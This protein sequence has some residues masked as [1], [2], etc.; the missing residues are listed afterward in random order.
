MNFN[1]FYLNSFKDSNDI[2]DGSNV[3]IK[4]NVAVNKLNPSQH[5]DVSGN[6]KASNKLIANILEL[7]GNNITVDN[8]NNITFN[9]AKFSHIFPQSPQISALVLIMPTMVELISVTPLT[10]LEKHT[11]KNFLS[12]KILSV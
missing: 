3:I 11:Y 4:G 12:V 1:E 10:H 2:L 5:I 6:I 9:K 8:S 7:S